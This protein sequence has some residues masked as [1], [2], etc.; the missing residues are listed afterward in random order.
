MADIDEIKRKIDITEADIVEAKKA[1]DKEEV[2]ALRALLTEQQKEKNILL[3]NQA[4]TGQ[5]SPAP[6]ASDK[7]SNKLLIELLKNQEK[8]MSSVK[9]TMEKQVKT[10][11]KQVEVLGG[12]GEVLEEI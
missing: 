12:I 7:D 8:M 6:T 9:K 11:E 1:G 10:M 3:A 2:K 5:P 4:S